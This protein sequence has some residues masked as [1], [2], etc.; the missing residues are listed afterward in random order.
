MATANTKAETAKGGG[1]VPA[2]R[3]TARR[4][5]FRRAGYTFTGEPTDIPLADLT[6]ANIA[7]LRG[8]KLLVVQDVEID[9]A[10]D[11]APAA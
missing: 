10:P 11:A 5:T 3:V 4:D 1:K 7:Q 9:A 8:E 2:L 6:K